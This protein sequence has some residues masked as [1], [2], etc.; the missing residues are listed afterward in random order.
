MSSVRVPLGLGLW[1]GHLDLPACSIFCIP[2]CLGLWRGQLG[3]DPGPLGLGLWRGGVAIL[4]TFQRA[5]SFAFRAALA[6]GVV[7]ILSC[8][9]A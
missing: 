9:I 2:G 3:L 7:L 8:Q 4:L 5:R 6:A 1:R